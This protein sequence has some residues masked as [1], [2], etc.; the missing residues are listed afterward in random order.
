ML[1]VWKVGFDTEGRLLASKNLKVLSK[2]NKTALRL[3]GSFQAARHLNCMPGKPARDRQ[4]P[5][6]KAA[7]SSESIEDKKPILVDAKKALIRA[8]ANTNRGKETTLDQRKQ[9]L[10][11]II[12]LENTN[13]TDNPVSS[14]FLSGYWSLLYTAPI[15]E[16]TSDKYAG[17]QEGPFLARVKPLA[18]GS[19]KQTR[20]SQVIDVENGV[21][22]NIADFTFFGKNGTLN[23]EG[24]AAPSCVKE[25][26][27]TRLEVVFKSFFVRIGGWTS[28]R[29]SLQWINPQGWVDT[30]YLDQDMRIG[31][32]DK[33]SVFVAVRA[34]M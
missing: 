25:K 13:P 19:I 3:D 4:Y 7:V 18:F 33:G 31:R 2:G 27:T 15:N 26:E 30:T 8:V 17:T 21:A 12:E 9:I 29:I 14:A 16:M 28:P 1:F 11:M 23:I 10:K 32:G 6:I 20:S 24:L 22:K 34:K 5:C